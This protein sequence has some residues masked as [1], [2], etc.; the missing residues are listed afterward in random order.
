MARSLSLPR[1]AVA[2]ADW[3]ITESGRKRTVN[4]IATF[5][6]RAKGRDRS[7][8]AVEKTLAPANVDH[9]KAFLCNARNVGL[10]QLRP[11]PRAAACIPDVPARAASPK[12]AVG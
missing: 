2:N 3:G 10:I 7:H 12:A 4:R 6:Q 11:I 8:M 5:L 9:F 1:D